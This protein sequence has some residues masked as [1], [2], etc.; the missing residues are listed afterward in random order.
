M[1]E[2]KRVEPIQ[3][4]DDDPLFGRT[5]PVDVSGVF[6]N[7]ETDNDDTMRTTASMTVTSPKANKESERTDTGAEN[8]KSRS[9]RLPIFVGIGALLL[10]GAGVLH[11]SGDTPQQQVAKVE[12]LKVDTPKPATSGLEIKSASE[13]PA[14]SRA[15]NVTLAVPDGQKATIAIRNRSNKF[16]ARWEASGEVSLGD[17]VAGTYVT[18]LTVEGKGKIRKKS[19]EVQAGKQCAFTFD[20]SA[21]RWDGN[22]E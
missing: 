19:F 21:R 15:T 17:L 8:T 20:F 7:T 4:P 10:I 9:L 1:V 12:N 13:G 5:V 14:A 6:S 3:S 2:A 18:N 16:N 11:F 22:C